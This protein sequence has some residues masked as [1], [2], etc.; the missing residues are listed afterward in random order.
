MGEGDLA[1]QTSV[2]MGDQLDTAL[3]RLTQFLVEKND[4][5]SLN[6]IVPQVKVAQKV[7]LMSNW[8]VWE[9]IWVGP[10]GLC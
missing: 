4:V 3:E 1:V 6:A 9:I 5:A 2:A 8:K 7:E 10:E